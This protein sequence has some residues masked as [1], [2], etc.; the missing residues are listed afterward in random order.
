MR[1]H[2]L[3]SVLAL[4]IAAPAAAQDAP[5]RPAQVTAAAIDRGR[6]LFHG[7]PNCTA[8][9]GQ[10]GRGTQNGPNLADDEWLRGRGTFEDLVERVVHGVSGR[11]SSTG[12]AMP[13]RGMW[14]DLTDEDVTALAAYVWSLRLEPPDR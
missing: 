11:E 4:T 14:G 1:L 7:I 8:C 6:T 5:R 9:H 3:V 10:A 13:V 12:G 2:L